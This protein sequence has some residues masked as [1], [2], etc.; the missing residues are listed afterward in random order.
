MA[1][2]HVCVC[3]DHCPLDVLR[4]TGE[5]AAWLFIVS[6]DVLAW[7]VSLGVSCPRS[8]THPL[9][10]TRVCFRRS[11]RRH[12]TLGPHGRTDDSIHT[13]MLA[14]LLL[15]GAASGRTFRAEHLTGPLRVGEQHK[16]MCELPMLG[17]GLPSAAEWAGLF[18]A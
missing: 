17:G 6:F 16:C 10:N 9:H 4:C 11:S 12:S 14:P 18:P 8:V 3:G 13:S 5:S 7:S 1:R 2:W 15:L